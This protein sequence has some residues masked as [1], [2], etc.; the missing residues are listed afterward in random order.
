MANSVT[1]N[2]GADTKS[3]DRGI[4]DVQQGAA[5][6]GKSLDGMKRHAEEAGGGFDG[7]GEKLEGSTGKF[8][9]GKDVVDGFSDSM[10][11]LGVALPGPLGNISMMAGG[12]A[13]LADGIATTALPLL[14]KLWAVL[15][16]NPL[17]LVIGAVALLV[18]GFVIAYKKSE[19]F[20]D[21]VNGV[22]DAVKRGAQVMA[23][24][25]GKIAGTLFAPYRLAFNM[26]ADAWNATVGNLNFS[27][28]G[29]VPKIGGNSFG[30]PKIPHFANGGTML[31][32]GLAVVGERG[33]E[34]VA[35]PGGARVIPNNQV[36]GGGGQ[37]IVLQVDG[38]S[39]DLFVQW[40][41]KKARVLGGG[42]VQAAFG[43]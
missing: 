15:M 9:G 41:R 39:D 2:F 24:V 17:F 19:T 28:P 26:I 36:S 16:A 37:T 32:G 8:R 40:L 42:S 7:I 23:D 11:S 14:S 1:V 43:R 3:F 35:M 10:E 12:I 25:F 30:V 22:F 29:W 34:L 31:D 20:R 6:A 13:D 5:D 4:K 21:I 18:A 27:I 38:P 33:P